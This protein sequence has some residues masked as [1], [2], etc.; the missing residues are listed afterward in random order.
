MFSCLGW[1]RGGFHPCCA[2][3][4]AFRHDWMPLNVS[5]KLRYMAKMKLS[6]LE[7]Y[8]KNEA[9]VRVQHGCRVAEKTEQRREFIS[10]KTLALEGLQWALQRGDASERVLYLPSIVCSLVIG[11]SPGYRCAKTFW[12]H[13]ISGEGKSEKPTRLHPFDVLCV[14]VVSFLLHLSAMAVCD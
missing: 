8:S 6:P 10:W 3:S 14:F 4:A 9:Q 2:L 7:I 11:R 1:G 13:M 12:F 5:S